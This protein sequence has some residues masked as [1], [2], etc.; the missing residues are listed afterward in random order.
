[1][2]L[3]GWNNPLLPWLEQAVYN[4]QLRVEQAKDYQYL[5]GTVVNPHTGI[6]IVF[7]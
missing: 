3:Q 2:T 5:V 1:M 6:R 7:Q 4:G